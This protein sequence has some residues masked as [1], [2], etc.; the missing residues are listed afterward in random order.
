M[1]W[2]RSPGAQ[3]NQN[4][5]VLVFEDNNIHRGKD[6]PSIHSGKGE[7]TEEVTFIFLIANVS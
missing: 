5:S 2:E 3:S 1:L 6:I 7:Q 4:R